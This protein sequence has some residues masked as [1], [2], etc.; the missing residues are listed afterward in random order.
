MVDA[1]D[2]YKKY[3][4]IMPMICEPYNKFLQIGANAVPDGLKSI[5][6]IGIGTGN[7]SK[8]VKKRFPNIEVYGVDMNPALLDI[9]ATKIKGLKKYKLDINNDIFPKVDYFISSMTLH[10]LDTD[11]RREG[12]LKIINNSNG[13]INFDIVLDDEYNLNKA[14]E[15]V[16]NFVKKSVTEKKKLEEIEYELRVKDNYMH[17]EEQKQIFESQGMNF[18]VLKRAQP[19]IV[20]R[21][22]RQ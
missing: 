2:F 5:C 15:S 14:V 19:Y 20:Y 17:I 11:K 12:L 7:F 3:D 8:L 22:S 21:V 10:H 16:L 9:A 1:K 4:E 6:D 18:E 13:L